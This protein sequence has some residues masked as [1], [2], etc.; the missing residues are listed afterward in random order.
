[1]KKVYSILSLIVLTASILAQETEILL[2]TEQ[3]SEVSYSGYGGPLMLATGINNEFGFCIGGKG[4]AVFNEKLVFGGI[5]FGM[6]NTPKFTG[7]NL[8]DDL[9]TPLEM[10]FG[11][12]GIFLE[13][14]F[15]FGDRIVF[16]IPLNI[17][18]GGIKI[19]ESGMETE[20]ESSAFLIIEPGINIDFHVSDFYTQSLFISYRQAIGSSLTN[21]EDENISGMNVGLIFKFKA[22]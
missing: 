13:Y 1:M 20:I 6:V 14:I 8:S 12:G 7:N 15:N 11:A 18:A 22:K 5:G 21:L 19:K 2:N 3:Q 16:S 17:M 10:S 9:N 4:G